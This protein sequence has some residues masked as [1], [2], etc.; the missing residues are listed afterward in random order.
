MNRP[1][2]RIHSQLPRQVHRYRSIAV[3][4]IGGLFLAGSLFAATTLVSL[5]GFM[6]FQTVPL[7]MSEKTV[8]PA[9]RDA[10]MAAT[11]DSFPPA[12]RAVSGPLAADVHEKI[13]TALLAASLLLAIIFFFCFRRILFARLSRLNRSVLAMVAGENREIEAGGLTVEN[14]DF[15]LRELLEQLAAEQ[16]K[17]LFQ[18]FTRADRSITRKFG[19]T[20]LGLTICKSLADNRHAPESQTIF[21]GESEILPEEMAANS[22]GIDMRAGL[23]RTMGNSTLYFNLLTEFVEKYREVPAIMREE[24]KMPSFDSVRQT[25]HTLKGVSGS[26]GMKTLYVRCM[27][28]EASIKRKKIDECSNLVFEIQ[29]E[30]EK[31]CDFLRQ[32]LDRHRNKVSNILTIKEKMRSGSEDLNGLLAS[33]TDSLRNNSSK[34]ITE[35]GRLRSCLEEEDRLVFTRIEKHIN[36][37]DFDKARILLIRWQDSLRK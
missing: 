1:T 3:T 22:L 20:G 16:E 12:L 8:P 18:P 33:L 11:A 28:L 26:L 35:I 32:Y 23:S 30:T 10:R 7:E 27:Q 19:G 24:L 5:R 25:V 31:I 2:P 4:V 6:N 9:T 21:S 34:A 17:K 14:I 15:D 29:T 37:L 36:D 13:L